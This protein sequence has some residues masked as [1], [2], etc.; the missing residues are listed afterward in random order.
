MG[1]LLRRLE[2]PEVLCLG[3][4]PDGV[5]RGPDAKAALEVEERNDEVR[6][7]EIM[8]MGMR[9]EWCS[10]CGERGNMNGHRCSE[11]KLRSID[12]AHK[13]ALTRE[14]EEFLGNQPGTVPSFTERLKEGFGKGSFMGTAGDNW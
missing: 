9:S 3:E 13:A 6:E 12:T 7:T 4:L 1:Q 5:S 11:K 10:I 14:A 8:R 2:L